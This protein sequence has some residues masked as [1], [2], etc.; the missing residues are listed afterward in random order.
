MIKA[1]IF[2]IGDVLITNTH[3]FD[4]IV[5]EFHLDRGKALPIY[6]EAIER[7]GSGQIDEETFWNVLKSK[8]LFNQKVP[9]PSPLVKS[10]IN[11]KVVQ[12]VIDIVIDLKKKGYK[13]ALLSNT[14]ESHIQEIEKLDFFKYFD[15]K[16]F[17][18]EVKSRKPFADIY[19]LTLKKLDVSPEEAIFIDNNDIFVKGAEEV[20]IRGIQFIDSE[21]LK[22]DL[23]KLKVNL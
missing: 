7:L 14:I 4:D 1:I 3:V 6:I 5:D 21:Q 13:L 8:L 19:T 17:S 20:G 12:E 16:I 18:Y 2:D 9:S 22:Q 23:R 15:I 10:H 11:V